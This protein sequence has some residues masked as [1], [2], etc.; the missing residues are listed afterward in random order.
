MNKRRRF[1]AKR[2]RRW[3]GVRGFRAV[4][5]YAKTYQNWSAGLPH[6]RAAH[7]KAEEHTALDPPYSW[8]QRPTLPGPGD[9]NYRESGQW[10]RDQD[11]YVR[12]N[13]A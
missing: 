3:G 8:P 5:V 7:M 2:F 4:A 12:L 6:E 13:R 1:K 10:Q 9:W 11:R